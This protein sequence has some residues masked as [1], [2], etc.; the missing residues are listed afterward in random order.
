MDNP[1]NPFDAFGIGVVDD[2]AQLGQQLSASLADHRGLIELSALAVLFDTI[3]GRPFYELD[4]STSSLQARVIMSALHRPAVTDRLVSSGQIR[5]N[6]DGYGTTTADITTSAGV[7]VTTGLTRNVRVGRSS[8][9]RDQIGALAD[10]EPRPLPSTDR[11]LSG[12][13]IIEAIAHGDHPIGPIGELVDG[14]IAV[15]D[16]ATRFTSVT[17]PWMANMMGT[18]H[19]GVIGAI[20]ALACSF[21]AQAHTQPGTEYQILDFDIGFYRSPAVDGSPVHVDVTPVKV[22]RRIGSFEAS[23]RTD[24]RTLLARATADVRFMPR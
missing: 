24:D 23:M 15:L 2:S 5:M 21:G 17:A 16:G 4:E 22:G 6:D 1:R 8:T 14:S 9:S 3:G 20:G 19:G 12:H 18:M 11:N 13:K 10:P 7:L